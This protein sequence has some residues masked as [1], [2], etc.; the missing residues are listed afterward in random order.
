MQL[1]LKNGWEKW[2]F[3]AWWEKWSVLQNGW[4]KL[5]ALCSEDMRENEDCGG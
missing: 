2:C 4:E 3:K 1:D 5:S